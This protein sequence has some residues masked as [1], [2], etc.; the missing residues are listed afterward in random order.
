[1]GQVALRLWIYGAKI[2][3]F[4]NFIGDF[5]V[6]SIVLYNFAEM[7]DVIRCPYCG[8]ILG[9]HEDVRGSG[10]LYLWCKQCRKERHIPIKRLSLDQ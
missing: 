6:E 2:I 10:D 5:L 3:N 9:K 8:K 7:K 1:M 4:F